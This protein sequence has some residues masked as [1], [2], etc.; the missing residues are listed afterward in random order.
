MSISNIYLKKKI[1]LRKNIS[2]N[3]FTPFH[4]L[5]RPDVIWKI[6]SRPLYHVHFNMI[7]TNSWHNCKMLPLCPGS[8][9]KLKIICYQFRKSHGG[10]KTIL[11]PSY[12]HNGISYTGKMTFLYWIRTQASVYWI[13]NTPRYWCPVAAVCISKKWPITSFKVLKVLMKIMMPFQIIIC[14]MWQ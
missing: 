8:S 5:I 11:R 14:F 12:L 7:H 4:V 6:L 3:W 13:C 2:F 9:L 10:N 1:K